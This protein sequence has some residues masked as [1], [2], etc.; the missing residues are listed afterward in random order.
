[1]KFSAVLLV[2]AFLALQSA[3]RINFVAR[4]QQSGNTDGTSSNATLVTKYPPRVMTAPNQLCPSDLDQD[5]A[6]IQVE[7]DIHFILHNKVLPQLNL[8]HNSETNPA[9]SCSEHFLKGWDSSYY[10][11]S[12]NETLPV[13]VYCDM[14]S[15][16]PPFWWLVACS[17]PQHDRSH[18]A[19]SR[20]ME[21]AYNTNQDLQK[22]YWFLHE[23][24]NIQHSWNAI[25]MCVWENHWIPVWNTYLRYF[26]FTMK[27]QVTTT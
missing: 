24:S 20:R 2:T 25:Q 23:F 18:T 10:W 8:E 12:A 5:D 16:L 3:P 19:M 11:V 4:V 17:L 1:M 27:I 22:S 9:A 26:H 21:R 13:E 7:Q 14:N 6:H 15:I